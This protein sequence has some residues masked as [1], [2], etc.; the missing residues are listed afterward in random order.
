[1]LSTTLL[2]G[3]LVIQA[4][5]IIS[6]P[7]SYRS[8]CTDCLVSHPVMPV[9][10][11]YTQEEAYTV[12]HNI[13]MIMYTAP[14]SQTSRQAVVDTESLGSGGVRTEGGPC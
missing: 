12:L 1:M 11:Y 4:A 13:I 2:Q 14:L 8:Y 9:A 10:S 6:F 7:H 5:G 3:Q